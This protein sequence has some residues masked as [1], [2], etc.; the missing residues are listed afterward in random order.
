[1]N[2]SVSP[3]L[4]KLIAEQAQSLGYQTL[5]DYLRVVF[6]KP[7]TLP[8]SVEVSEEE[9]QRFLKDLSAES[10]LPTLPRD[11]SRA[12]IYADHD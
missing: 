2:L 6:G 8:E 4:Q 1:M 3:E 11:F 10:D 12:D 5:D 9:F 7:V